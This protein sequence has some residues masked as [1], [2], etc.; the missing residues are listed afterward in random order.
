MFAMNL[1]IKQSPVT[2]KLI[3]T[4]VVVFVFALMYRGLVKDHEWNTPI[5]HFLGF[6]SQFEQVIR[7]PWT[8]ISAVFFHVRLEHLIYNLLFLFFAGSLFEQLF[9]GRK[10][11]MLYL[12]AGV[13]GNITQLLAAV[14]APDIFPL[15]PVFGASGAIM[16]IFIAIAVYRPQLPV[17]IFGG[18][19]LPI[20]VLA[21]FFL[22]LDLIGIGGNG[23]TAH[24]AHLGGALIGALTMIRKKGSIGIWNH[25]PWFSG[26]GKDSIRNNNARFKTDEEYNAIKHD[27]EARTDAIL[28]KISR[29][30]Y[31]SLSRE[32]KEFLFKQ[33]KE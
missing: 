13:F 15:G 1:Q 9:S 26:H 29:S 31:E 27:S 19:S 28:D 21:L 18:F 23:G 4:N 25:I 3:I 32:E 33:G 20:Y 14:I 6:S 16:G 24:M 8:V 2:F 7:F 17:L 10:L 11:L 12:F 5:E 30:G 22:I